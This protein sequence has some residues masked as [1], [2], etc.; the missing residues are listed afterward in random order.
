MT[1]TA[2]HPAQGTGKPPPTGTG[3][4]LL[5]TSCALSTA[6]RVDSEINNCYQQSQEIGPDL[7]SENDR[8]QGR[9]G[10][11][12]TSFVFST[13]S[14][15][16]FLHIL[17]VS[18]SVTSHNSHGP[19]RLLFW[20]WLHAPHSRQTSPRTDRHRVPRIRGEA[21]AERIPVGLPKPVQLISM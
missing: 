19:R 11:L 18:E 13:T 8:R 4:R 17:H 15:F 3:I 12:M 21:L 2:G 20:W 7:S 9:G 6:G 14:S 10:P 16:C 5:H 1:W